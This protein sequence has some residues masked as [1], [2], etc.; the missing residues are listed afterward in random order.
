M[1]DLQGLLPKCLWL[2]KRPPGKGGVIFSTKI[3]FQFNG[4]FACFETEWASFQN[5]A[6]RYATAVV[7]R[8]LYQIKTIITTKVSR[9]NAC[10]N[11]L[12][13]NRIGFPPK[14]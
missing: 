6:Q 9:A 13:F 11:L 3:R 14:F 1:N 8:C 2:S 5:F 4:L 12:S 7:Y 10:K